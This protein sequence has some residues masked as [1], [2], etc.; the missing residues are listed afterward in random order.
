MNAQTKAGAFYIFFAYLLWGLFPIYWKLLGH[1]PAEEIL[2]NRVFWSFASMFLL[3]L[4]TRKLGD[5]QATLKMMREKPKEAAALV[6]A[7][8]LV[9]G[10]W[11]LFI[12]AI[13][14]DRV[15]ETSLG[16]YIN[17]LMSVLL[18]VFVL[19]ESL[20]KAQIFSVLFAAI[21][22]AVLTISYGQFPWIS[23]GL[24][25]SF[26]LYGLMKKTVQVEA[27]VGLTLETFAVT[28]IAVVFLAYWWS[29]GELALVSGSF[30][31]ALLLILGG[32]ITA[33]PLLLFAEG[34][35]KIPLSM[36]G[37]LQYITP[38][39]TLLLGVFVYDEPFSA[40]QF[41]SFSFIWT[42]LAIFTFSQIKWS[43]K[44]HIAARNHKKGSA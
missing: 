34:A 9:S 2:A 25:V 29:K 30:S 7:S 3:L 19:K 37:I 40:T 43:Q 33:L 17:P 28:P 27:A 22:V 21:G 20:S 42:A 36:I 44:R 35:P 6:T 8:F 12:W 39:M 18:G 31:T 41:I 23:L 11:F 38:T 1:V 26:A 24:A 5:L 16:Y 15:I 4:I 13:N 14:N 32:A 10:N